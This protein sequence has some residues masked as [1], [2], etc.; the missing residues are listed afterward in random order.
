MTFFF[1][2][3]IL[4]SPVSK[5]FVVLHN[6]YKSLYVKCYVGRFSGS[7]AQCLCMRIPMYALCRAL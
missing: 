7:A 5:T 3:A 4:L 1:K 6:A 2:I